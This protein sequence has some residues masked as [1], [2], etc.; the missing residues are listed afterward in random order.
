MSELKEKVIGRLFVAASFVVAISS[1]YLIYRAELLH[2]C[3][4][5]ASESGKF[6]IETK[7]CD[8][9]TKLDN[10]EIKEWVTY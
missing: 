9:L 3:V 8:Y 10:K 7:E 5:A 4:N 1:V 2:D 6:Y